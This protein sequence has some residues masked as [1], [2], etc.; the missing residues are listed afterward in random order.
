MSIVG[1]KARPYSIGIVGK[2]NVGKSTFFSAATLAPAEI[3]NYP[4]TTIKPNRGIGYI[5][6]HCVHE[7]FGVKDNPINSLCLNGMRMIPVELV[8]C[9]GLVPGAWEGRGLGNQ[10]LDEIRKADALLHIVDAAGATDIEGRQCKPGRHDPLVD[11]HFLDIEIAMWMNSI[12]KRD[13]IRMARAVE[14]GGRGVKLLNELEERLSGLSIKRRHIFEAVQQSG[15]NAAKP[16]SWSEE[17][18][19]KFADIL[20]KI[21]KPMLIAANKI[22]LPTAEENVERLKQQGLTVIPCSAEA[23]LAMRRAAEKKW[24]DY[25]PGDCNYKVLTPDLLTETQH[26]ALQTIKEKILT[27]HGSTGVQEAINTAYFKLLNCIVVYPVEDIEKLCNHKGEILPDAYI[28]PYGT[29][30]RE[31]AYIIHT[32]LGDNFIYAIEAREKNRIGESY[33]LKDRDIITIISAKKRA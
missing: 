22:D 26:K 1:G 24:I 30:A 18:L 13:W 8:D 4:F 12:I 11:V 6:T 23:E 9:A 32:E 2:P 10:F 16:T 15:L 5:R 25:T 29:T 14:A 27:P 17:E 3:A 19:M 33:L 28:V 7:E 21:S 31:L 20:R